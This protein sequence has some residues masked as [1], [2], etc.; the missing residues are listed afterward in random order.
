MC[1]KQT[2]RVMDISKGLGGFMTNHYN[3]TLVHIL[4]PLATETEFVKR[5][6]E[7]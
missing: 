5:G 4:V 1:V 6:I 2:S 7:I 3:Y